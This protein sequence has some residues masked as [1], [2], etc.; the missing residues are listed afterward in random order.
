M[1][2]RFLALLL[3]AVLV[4]GTSVYAQQ[5]T[6]D[7]TEADETTVTPPQPKVPQAKVKK[8]PDSR[9]LY[10]LGARPNLKRQQ[11]PAIGAP[12]NIL[13]RPFV[14]KGSIKVP[15]APSAILAEG[16]MPANTAEA[17][18]EE[19]ALDV[20]NTEQVELEGQEKPD[21]ALGNADVP[22]AEEE[23]SPAEGAGVAVAAD[24]LLEAGALEQLDPSGIA[25]EGAG[26]AYARE[27]WR[28]YDRMSIVGRLASFA[29]T[30]GS[31]SLAQIA[32]KIV[33][34]GTL[35]DDQASDTDIQALAEAR[36]GLLMQLGN[37]QG[38][39]DLLAALPVSHDWSALA[40]HYTNAYLLAGKVGDACELAS[41]RRASDNDA[42]WLRMIAF[43]DA[44][45]G[46]RNGVDFQLRI[47]E[48]VSD[49]QP[50][51]YQLIDQILVEAEQ[52]PGGVL[53]ANIALPG[54]MQVDVLEATMARLA[55]VEVPQLAPEDI[56][57]LAVGL[58]LSLPNVSPEAKTELMGLAVRRGW[59]NGALLAAFARTLSPDSEKEAAALQL[60]N[61][62]DRFAIDAVLVKLAAAAKVQADRPATYRRV[63]ERALKN[64]YL[65]VA[66]E[67]LLVLSPDLVPSAAMGGVMTRAALIS[68]DIETAAKWFRALR[69]Q[70]SGTDSEADDALI[71]VTPMMALAA[72]EGVPDLALPLLSRWWQAEGDNADRF[73]RANLLFT[74]AEAL[75]HTIGDEAWGWLEQGPAAFGGTVPATAQWRRFL[76]S[77][78]EGDTPKALAIAFRLL[79]EAGTEGVP[80]T[81]AGSIVGTLDELGMKAE[82]RMIAT[83]ILISQGL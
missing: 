7:N 79:S 31:P 9:N 17:S 53:A 14:P 67:S 29:A 10:F 25:V 64:G 40:R 48:E 15:P 19:T 59:A 39:T 34:S 37:R 77:A 46:N 54:S 74:V 83:E 73:K 33:L 80:A 26:V 24:S 41:E 38:Y 27:F 78:H 82:A 62:D 44:A 65:A 57:P 63:W 4:C 61:E 13:P 12:V 58:M 70:A 23:A 68:G 21:G 47:L 5:D 22:P 71:A 32:N 56:N 28:G 69:S 49:V 50:T 60:L 76:I 42:Y 45:R 30:A 43:C 52:P 35:L 55:R 8:T 66:G 18:L 11:G 6:E 3:A 81:L 75:G 20:E 1:M 16:E 36:L 2:R 51:F 72:N